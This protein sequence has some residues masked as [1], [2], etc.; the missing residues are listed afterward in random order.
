MIEQAPSIGEILHIYV[1][2]I[3]LSLTEEY[4]KTQVLLMYMYKLINVGD[5]WIF[6]RKFLLFFGFYSYLTNQILLAIVFSCGILT[7]CLIYILINR[8]RTKISTPSIPKL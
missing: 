5:S 7:M 4:Q 6:L 1:H 8:E 2:S 3:A